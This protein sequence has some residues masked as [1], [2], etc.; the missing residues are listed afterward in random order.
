MTRTASRDGFDVL[1][2]FTSPTTIYEKMRRIDAAADALNRDI[3][4]N[5]AEGGYR[6]AWKAWLAN[7]KAFFA[8]TMDEKIGN[9]FR[10]DDLD[11][12]VDAK[13][14][15]FEG[16][17][18]SY[19]DQRTPA[20]RPVPPSSQPTPIPLPKPGE[21]GG[22]RLPWWFWVGGTIA[23]AA[24]GY[25]G[26]RYYQEAQAKKRAIEK[27]VLPGVLGGIFGPK[28]G[29]SLAKAASARDPELV[30]ATS[31]DPKAMS[32]LARYQ[33]FAPVRRST[34]QRPPPK[35]LPSIASAIPDPG[36]YR[37]PLGSERG[38]YGYGG[39]GH[40]RDPY[41]LDHDLEE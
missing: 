15:E 19:A 5:V 14:A 35:A 21:G 8:K 32:A 31:A 29:R 6:T 18:R 3:L 25:L 17:R 36:P 13:A 1:T 26:Y 34:P 20:G 2:G 24:A 39:A 7:W 4:A 40:D 12:E 27:D 23:V 37:D 22:S 10:S 11:E 9:V 30:L 28:T 33:A 38:A 41:F 16:F